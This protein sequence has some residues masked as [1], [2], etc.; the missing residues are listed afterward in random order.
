LED[1]MLAPIRTVA[2]LS[3]ESCA[4]QL[5]FLQPLR[6]ARIEDSNLAASPTRRAICCR[7]ASWYFS[8]QTWRCRTEPEPNEP[9]RF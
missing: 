2:P 4:N 3:L 1:V 5:Y 8:A 7:R 6:L 9:F